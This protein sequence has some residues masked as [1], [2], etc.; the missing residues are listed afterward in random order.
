M[1]ARLAH[2]LHVGGSKLPSAA[3]FYFYTEEL[4]HT[5]ITRKR[6][7]NDKPRPMIII[8]ITTTILTLSEE[9]NRTRI[10][11]RIRKRK[12]RKRRKTTRGTFL[13]NLFH[14]I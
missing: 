8:I 1:A 9:E 10:R 2:K 14:Y 3:F 12:R 4:R 7:I 5:D 6:G 13:R 11:K